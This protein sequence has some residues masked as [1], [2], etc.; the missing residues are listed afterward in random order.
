[1]ARGNIEESGADD[2]D[3]EVV[4]PSFKEMIKL[5]RVVEESSMVVCTEVSPGVLKS[6]R[7]Y[8][9]D[10]QRMSTEGAKQTTLDTFIKL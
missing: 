8:R 1:M 5:C 4:P 2:D 3:P 6:L 10:L 7:R 9:G